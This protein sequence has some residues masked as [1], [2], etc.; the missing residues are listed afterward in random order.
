MSSSS[1]KIVESIFKL[2]ESKE[3]DD[4]IPSLNCISAKISMIK[5]PEV[6][7]MKLKF[8]FPHCIYHP[9]STI[10]VFVA[11]IGKIPNRNYENT[12]RIYEQMLNKNQQQY[13][14]KVITYHQLKSEFN[15]FEAKRKLATSF[16]LFIA[17]ERIIKNIANLTGKEFRVRRKWPIPVAL[18]KYVATKSHKGLINA[19]LKHMKTDNVILTGHGCTFSVR[20]CT[21]QHGF[22]VCQSQV[23]SLL[24][25]LDTLVPGGIA[26]IRS[27]HLECKT[28][29]SLPLFLSEVSS[30]VL[31][32]DVP[33]K[34]I[35]IVDNE[36]EEITTLE[37]GLLVKFINPD[38]FVIVDSKSGK[39]VDE[40]QKRKRRK[41]FDLNLLQKVKKLHDNTKE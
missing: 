7:D 30:Q 4:L 8:K 41:W 11:D 17:D 34:D 31:N 28:C 3:N 20:L 32:I 18:K 26:N 25:Q 35:D 13:K 6:K 1:D 15:T 2:I 29:P 21:Y 9:S 27:V 10:C 38:E 22:N 19:I 40:H 39:I 24:K 5:I 12:S 37:D 23:R 33:K 16:D 14:F 36:G